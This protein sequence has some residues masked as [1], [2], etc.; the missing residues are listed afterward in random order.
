MKPGDAYLVHCGDWHTFVGRLVEQVSP[1][2]YRFEK[3]SK[4]SDTNNGDVW[5]E[6]AAGDAE[7]REAATYVHNTTP[8]FLP[9]SIAA[10]EWIG[11]VPQE[12]S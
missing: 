12:W 3:C 6:L 4:I 1:L 5:H 9:V 11:E 8:V 10:I 7:K 2:L